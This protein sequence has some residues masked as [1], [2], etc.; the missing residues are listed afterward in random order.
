MRY[1]HLQEIAYMLQHCFPEATELKI[2]VKT[3]DKEHKTFSNI[4]HEQ[5]NGDIIGTIINN[6][7]I[8]EALR[9]G[10]YLFS[11][12][13]FPMQVDL[14]VSSPQHELHAKYKFPEK[15]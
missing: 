11:H 14:K 13:R 1:N 8:A 6:P 9:T 10:A 15:V 2:E 12:V 5:I 4:I 3:T 7:E